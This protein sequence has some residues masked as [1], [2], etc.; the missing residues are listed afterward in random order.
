LIS[1]RKANDLAQELL[2]K[3]VAKSKKRSR[4]AAQKTIDGAVF[5]EDNGS[6]ISLTG[7]GYWFQ[8]RRFIP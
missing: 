2:V 7:L 3:K 6:A 4:D 5:C 1:S 8:H